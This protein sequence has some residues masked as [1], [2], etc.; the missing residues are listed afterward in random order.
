MYKNLEYIS[1]IGM[2]REDWLTHRRNSIGGSDAAA[3]VGLSDYSSPYS[4]WADKV[5]LAPEKED[6]EAM[7][8][9]RDLEEYVAQRFT[10]Q[11][12]KKV[13]R[14]NAIIK[15]PDIPFAHANVDRLVIGEDAGLECKT[16]SVLNMKKFKNGEYPENYYVQ[17]VHYMMVT[18]CKRWYL[19]VL[20]LGRGF[21]V[22]VI[23]RDEDEIKALIEAE[24]NFWGYVS[25]KTAPPADGSA[26]T[27]E[28]ISTIYRESSD[29]TMCDV[30]PLE[31]NIKL[32][33]QYKA[34]IKQLEES[35]NEHLNA[36]KQYM[37]DSERGECSIAKIQWKTQQRNTFDF[38]RYQKD[39]PNENFNSYIKT[40]TSRPFLLTERK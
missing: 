23:E 1:T 4:V 25:D 5:G 28:T 15:N 30:S 13:R 10:E 8:Q 7:R 12:G 6:N 3:I 34:S 36:I 32:Y 22:F 40:S 19:A 11:T 21:M 17:C 27:A 26:V 31:Q 37:G 16:T 38:K 9:G 39:H 20:I 14:R 35:A 18:G 2:S 33:L 29:G 24:R